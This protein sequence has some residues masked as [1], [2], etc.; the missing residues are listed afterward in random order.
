MSYPA[1]HLVCR[2]LF[3]PP[4]PPTTLF[5][6]LTVTAA[7]SPLSCWPAPPLGLTL[8]GPSPSLF[9]SCFHHGGLPVTP[10][11]PGGLYPV[12]AAASDRLAAASSRL[13]SAPFDDQEIISPD[14]A[15][16]ICRWPTHL[17]A[18]VKLI[19]L[20]NNEQAKFGLSDLML[21]IWFNSR[22]RPR[23]NCSINPL[24][25]T[26][27][28]QIN[29]NYTAIRWL[30][31]WPLMSWVGCYIW[32]SEDGLGRPAPCPVPSSLYQM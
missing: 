31:H 1:R 6:P 23:P 11:F 15:C 29:W 4:P 16:R 10:P 14:C 5:P 2:S 32:Y 18:N 12:S 21:P 19:C 20:R 9:G 17:T 30:V 7:P 13:A 27:K 28:P 22:L 3:G 26:L 8:P 25:G 24:T